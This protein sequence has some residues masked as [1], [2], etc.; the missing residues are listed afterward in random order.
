MSIADTGLKAEQADLLLNLANN[1][2]LTRIDKR[3]QRCGA[4]VPMARGRGGLERP[5][6]GWVADQSLSRWRP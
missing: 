6:R 4:T 1:G 2:V 5:D 3:G